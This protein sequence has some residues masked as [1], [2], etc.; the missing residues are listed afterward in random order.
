MKVTVAIV[1]ALGVFTLAVCYNLIL[2]HSQEIS[3]LLDAPV[4]T[5]LAA[6]VSPCLV[7]KKQTD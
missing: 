4:H 7:T 1:V 2:K 6:C 5:S 3:F